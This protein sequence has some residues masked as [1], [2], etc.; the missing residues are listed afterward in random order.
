MEDREYQFR[1]LISSVVKNFDEWDSSKLNTAY[2]KIIGNLKCRDFPKKTAEEVM[3]DVLKKL[4]E[5][6]NTLAVLPKEKADFEQNFKYFEWFQ[7]IRH[8]LITWTLDYK[9]IF[10]RELGTL[11]EKDNEKSI[12]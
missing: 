12:F 11:K 9:E 3:Y 10:A 7:Q 5:L 1:I 8:D 2:K 4:D 6:S